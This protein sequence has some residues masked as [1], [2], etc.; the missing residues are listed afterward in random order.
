MPLKTRQK[1]QASDLVILLI[2]DY[3]LCDC[4]VFRIWSSTHAHL[5]WRETSGTMISSFL[6]KYFLSLPQDQIF[7]HKGFWLTYLQ[8]DR[9][10][11]LWA[12]SLC[13][14]LSKGLWKHDPNSSLKWIT[15]VTLK[16]GP[17]FCARQDQGCMIW[18]CC[19]LSQNQNSPVWVAS[20]YNS[21]KTTCSLGQQCKNYIEIV[22][23][24]CFL[25]T[26]F[27]L[28]KLIFICL[29]LL[30]VIFVSFHSLFCVG[31]FCTHSHWLSSQYRHFLWSL[32]YVNVSGL[33]GAATFF[34][35]KMG[36]VD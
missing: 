11:H 30:A 32:S 7:F 12:S 29:S 4:S 5:P 19:Y 8:A 13:I 9:S 24:C 28:F 26:I 21:G 34:L 3:K 2:S 20:V 18:M 33:H 17:G 27:F 23:S 22:A 1:P 31:L 36:R 15:E 35:R 14:C 16:W 25:L 6:W 10:R